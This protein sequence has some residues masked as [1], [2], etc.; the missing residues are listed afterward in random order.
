MIMIEGEAKRR[1]SPTLETVRMIEDAIK[2]NNRKYTKTA[3]WEN[4]P[5]KVMYQTYKVALD[6]LIDSNK[7]ALNS[8]KVTWMYYPEVFK[9]LLE[10][11][12]DSDANINPRDI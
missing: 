10:K 2:K 4:L 11:T 7:V 5:K 9:K 1:P 8:H 12:V 6:Y 3:L